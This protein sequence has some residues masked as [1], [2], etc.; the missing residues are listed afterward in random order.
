MVDSVLAKIWVE[1]A[2]ITRKLYN[3]AVD[4]EVMT[5]WIVLRLTRKDALRIRSA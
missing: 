3:F 5:S 2:T 4:N 1:K